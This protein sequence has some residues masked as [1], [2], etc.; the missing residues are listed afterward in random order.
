MKGVHLERN[1]PL[2]APETAD[3]ATARAAVARFAAGSAGHS[4]LAQMFTPP[5]TGVGMR[6]LRW[7]MASN[8]QVE[9]GFRP[10]FGQQPD[11]APEA[12]LE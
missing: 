2:Q 8:L 7:D 1:K 12:A 4:A 10:G 11:A 3:G 9:L 5:L 6:F